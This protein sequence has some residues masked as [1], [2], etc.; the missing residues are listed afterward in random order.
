MNDFSTMWL[1][2]FVGFGF[3]CGFLVDVFIEKEVQHKWPQ[4]TH[5]LVLLLIV[6]S[7]VLYASLTSWYWYRKERKNVNSR[8]VELMRAI[9]DVE[10]A[11]TVAYSC[12]G[13]DRTKKVVDEVEKLKTKIY[14]I[15][16]NE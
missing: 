11:A 6:G 4:S 1:A 2:R 14:T 7:A 10:K 15:L 12:H 5:Q 3:V 8:E 13:G 9:S 16:L